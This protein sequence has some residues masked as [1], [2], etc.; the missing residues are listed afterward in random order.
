MT[1][2]DRVMDTAGPN[3][4][5]GSHTHS[6]AKEVHRKRLESRRYAV[7]MV[8]SSLTLAVSQQ[9]GIKRSDRAIEPTAGS[10]QSARFSETITPVAD[11]PIPKLP[12][13]RVVK[14]IAAIAGHHA[15]ELRMEREQVKH[16]R[17]LV[18]KSSMKS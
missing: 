12:E 11:E 9:P 8:G 15:V 5:R 10:T 3:Y 4:P 14:E 16:G 2:F 13:P 18:E 7:V 6:R 1:P 17:R